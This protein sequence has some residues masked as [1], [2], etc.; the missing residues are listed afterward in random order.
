MNPLENHQLVFLEEGINT[1]AYYCIKPNPKNLLIFVHGFGGKSTATWGDFPILIK[2]FSQFN[3]SDVIFYGYK[4]KQIPALGNAELFYSHLKKFV[5]PR[6]KL[7]NSDR[8]DTI[9]KYE[10]ILFIGHSLGAIIIRKTLLDAKRDDPAWL[11]NSKIILFA[12]AHRG[13]HIHRLLME[14]IPESFKVFASAAKLLFPVLIDL[15]QDSETIKDLIK[16]NEKFL[17]KAGND[18]FTKATYIMASVKDKVV[19]K[20]RFCEDPN[21]EPIADKG[22][23]AICKPVL[24]TYEE[25]LAPLIKYIV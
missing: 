11:K 5:N 21:V 16:D 15:E 24:N 4:S 25:P 18:C 13:A 23:I 14:A 8:R 20:H 7:G 3:S 19:L 10:N 1:S 22:H 6:V 12:P 9:N 17:A 2:N